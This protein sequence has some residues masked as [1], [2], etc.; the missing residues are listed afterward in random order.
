MVSRML[1][2]LSLASGVLGQGG[3]APFGYTAGWWGNLPAPQVA[4]HLDTEDPET[5]VK[6]G[7]AQLVEVWLRE[8]GEKDWLVELQKNIT[9]EHVNP[10]FLDC[11]KLGANTCG[12]PE[13]DCFAYNPPA[14]KYILSPSSN[15]HLIPHRLLC[16][17]SSS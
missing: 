13:K 17:H 4:C 9:E 12:G 6:S 16:S 1:L 5:W 11:T 2:T 10:N 8:H 14:R 7:A 3:R 15:S